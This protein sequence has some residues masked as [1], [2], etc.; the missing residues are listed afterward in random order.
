M[1]AVHVGIST[2]KMG[3]GF[4]LGHLC[5][6]SEASLRVLGDVCSISSSSITFLE[7][8]MLPRLTGQSTPPFCGLGLFQELEVVAQLITS[9]VQP[10]E[11]CKGLFTAE[12]SIPQMGG[13]AVKQLLWIIH[14]KIQAQLSSLGTSNVMS[15]CTQSNKRRKHAFCTQ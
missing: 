11:D 15:I 1:L 6:V 3:S 4:I 7:R 5:K 14:G 9:H 10:A 12:S 2:M 13:S 8:C